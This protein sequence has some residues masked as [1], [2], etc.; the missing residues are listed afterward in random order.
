MRAM[1]LRDY[2]ER[3]PT[4]IFRIVPLPTVVADAAREA[5]RR[6][7]RD[8]AVIE[9]EAPR[10]S[11]CRHCL[12]WAQPGERV[13]L[14]PYASIPH[15][16][17]YAESGPIFAHEQLCEPYAATSEYP[18]D[19]CEGRVVR[20]YDEQDNMIGAV[21]LDGDE[22]EAVFAKLFA[23][24]ATAF[25]QVRSVTRGCFTFKVERAVHRD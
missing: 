22:P 17:P 15:G 19:F 11:P 1:D 6:G 18:P 2:I 12:R 25:L 9:V 20:A 7:A 3:M 21:V 10:S 14:F 23:N 5:A 16:R 24:P 8:H 13:I 4:P